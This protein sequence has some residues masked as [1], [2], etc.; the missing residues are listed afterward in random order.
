M[1]AFDLYG[2]T[3]DSLDYKGP[4]HYPITKEGDYIN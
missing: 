2:P 3:C 1:T 4:F